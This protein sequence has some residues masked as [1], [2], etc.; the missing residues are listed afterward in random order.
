MAVFGKSILLYLP[1]ATKLWPRLCFYSC[2]WFCPQGEGV[3]ASVHAGIPPPEQT[4]PGSRH[5]PRADTPREQT[6]PPQSRHPPL[7][8]ADT[9]PRKADSSIR[10]MSGRYASL[11]ECILVHFVFEMKWTL[12][13]CQHQKLH[14][15]IYWGYFETNFNAF[16]EINRQIDVFNLTLAQA[17]FLLLKI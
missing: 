5:P 13:L 15:N 16:G 7:L 14:C 6:T 8:G 9:P 2:L 11:L 12:K 17:S 10:S 4:P 3:S 1:G